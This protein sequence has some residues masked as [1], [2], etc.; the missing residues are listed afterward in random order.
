MVSLAGLHPTMNF[1][2]P[3]GT[4]P[5]SVH[6][7]ARDVGHGITSDRR[8]GRKSPPDLH[9][10]SLTKNI[11]VGHRPRFSTAQRAAA[12]GNRMDDRISVR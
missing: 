7:W 2:T 12:L 11:S 5:S 3:A 1:F 9:M 4:W 8:L 6:A 10:Y